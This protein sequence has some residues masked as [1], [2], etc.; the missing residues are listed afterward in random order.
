MK[1]FSI[2]TAL[3][4]FCVSLNSSLSQAQTGINPPVCNEDQMN[5]P[6]VLSDADAG[7]DFI[8]MMIGN[9]EGMK[10]VLA[11]GHSGLSLQ[12]DEDMKPKVTVVS[13]TQANRKYLTTKK[14]EIALEDIR[15][16]DVDGGTYIWTVVADTLSS[17]G[18]VTTYKNAVVKAK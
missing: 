16:T 1:T 14:Y 6:C 18:S 7:R 3:F 8:D 11:T 9:V 12:D 10:L 17:Y 5:T 15:G 2:F 4:L 13:N